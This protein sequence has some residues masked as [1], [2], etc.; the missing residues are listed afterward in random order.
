MFSLFKNK[1]PDQ[2]IGIFYICTGK[3]SVFWDGFYKSAEQYFCPGYTK[4][5]FVFTDQQ[6]D[7]GGNENIHIIHQ[8]KLGWPYDTLMRFH[9]FKKV[10]QEALTCDY[11]FFF[12]SNMVFL[13][14]VTANMILPDKGHPFVATQHP[15]YYESTADAP[16]ETDQASLAY[17]DF[18]QASHY[19]AGGLSGGF[20]EQYM[21]MSED[22]AA[23]IDDDLSRDIIAKWHDESHWNNFCSKHT[24]KVLHP[25]FITPESRLKTIPFKTYIVV[26]DKENFGGHAFLRA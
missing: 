8:E 18:H 4:R 22:I 26:L 3:Y 10:K 23:N 19:V 12:N 16:F 13:K 2:T 1:A 6:I 24:Y 17:T 7:T 21:K 5:Y 20:A 15:F 9:M 11:L 14:K 25:G